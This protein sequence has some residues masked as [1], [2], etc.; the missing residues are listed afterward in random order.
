[1]ENYERPEVLASYSVEE[2]T[3][4]AAVCIVYGPVYLPGS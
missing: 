4:E 3:E 2:L 1:M